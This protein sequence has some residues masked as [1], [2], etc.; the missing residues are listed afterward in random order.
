MDEVLDSNQVAQA[1]MEQEE[2]PKVDTS[3]ITTF[4]YHNEKGITSSRKVYKVHEDSD[5]IVGFDFNKLT[6]QERSVVHKVFDSMPV[7]LPPA[8]GTTSINYAALGINKA[9]FNKAYRTF[10]KRNIR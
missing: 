2:V 10:N 4:V 7:D 6:P 8:P 3:R 1:A 9:I 5:V